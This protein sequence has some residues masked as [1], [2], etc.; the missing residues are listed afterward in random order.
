MGAL[1]DVATLAVVGVLGFVGYEFVKNGG[2]LGTAAK[3]VADKTVY[4]L[5]SATTPIL[6]NYSTPPGTSYPDAVC[7]A[8]VQWRTNVAPA[9]TFLGIF[10]TGG[11]DPN[12]W[13]AFRTWA[14]T[15]SDLGD[16]GTTPPACWS[17]AGYYEGLPP[18]GLGY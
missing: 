13:N 4:Q 11:F 9:G 3:T 16:P 17:P 14:Q 12:D 1:D 5:T 10:P 7:Q 2:N 8:I 6:G 15:A 18:G